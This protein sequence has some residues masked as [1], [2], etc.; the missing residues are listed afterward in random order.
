ML[1]EIKIENTN[2]YE[3]KS[4]RERQDTSKLTNLKN[5]K[6]IKS[7]SKRKCFKWIENEKKNQKYTISL[8]FNW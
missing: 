6:R 8:F 4:K 2:Y 7:F 1:N 5:K 3:K